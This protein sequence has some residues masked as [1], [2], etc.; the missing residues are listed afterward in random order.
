VVLVVYLSRDAIPAGYARPCVSPPGM[1]ISPSIRLSQVC[2]VLPKR[3]KTGL[4]Y[5]S[6]DSLYGDSS[7]LTPKMLVKF[8]LVTP[9][10]GIKYR[11]GILLVSG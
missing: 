9:N 5:E 2:G 11:W 7:F 10:W 4:R 8:D 6:Y 1:S 3:L